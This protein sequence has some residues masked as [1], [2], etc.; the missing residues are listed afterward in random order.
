ML[1]VETSP[2]LGAMKEA[3]EQS[4]SEATQSFVVIAVVAILLLLSVV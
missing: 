2:D 4:S 1:L 3:T